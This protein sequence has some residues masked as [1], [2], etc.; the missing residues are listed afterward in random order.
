M[1]SIPRL[2]GRVGFPAGVLHVERVSH[3]Q[4]VS[5]VISFIIPRVN[6]L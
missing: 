2:Y 5:R 6:H 4:S 1:L 3:S